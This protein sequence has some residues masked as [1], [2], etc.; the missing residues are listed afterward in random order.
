MFFNLYKGVLVRDRFGYCDLSSGCPVEEE[1]ADPGPEHGPDPLLAD[2]TCLTVATPGG[3]KAPEPCVFP[4]RYLGVLHGECTTVG[5][6]RCVP[7]CS[8]QV[9]PDGNH[10]S[11]RGRFGHCHPEGCRRCC[12][13]A[14]PEEERC[15]PEV[16]GNERHSGTSPG[17]T[18]DRGESPCRTVSK[19]FSV[20]RCRPFC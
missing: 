13:P 17:L 6:D 16:A 4:F 12:I 18:S 9:D 3:T 8:V 15:R 14:D 7:W 1:E 20:A 19:N 10:V 11:G 2:E 5:D